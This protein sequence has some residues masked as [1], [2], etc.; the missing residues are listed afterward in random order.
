MINED[1]INACNE[2]RDDDDDIGAEESP[3]EQRRIN[4]DMGRLRKEILS[5][6]N[7]LRGLQTQ[8]RAYTGQDYLGL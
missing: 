5:Q 6:M 3:E 7:I 8:Y 1:L 4:A 2:V